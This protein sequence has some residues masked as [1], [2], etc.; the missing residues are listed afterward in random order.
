MDIFVY[1]RVPVASVA[2]LLPAVL[3]MQQS[4]ASHCS[5]AVS[6]K[7]RPEEKDG[8]QTWMEVYSQVPE[9]FLSELDA[10]VS[11]AG[12]MNVID[13][14]RHIETFVDVAACA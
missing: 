5:V 7:R 3:S 13:G 1:Y 6:L 4:V 8:C 14:L 10:A 12:L 9:N 11:A 2:T